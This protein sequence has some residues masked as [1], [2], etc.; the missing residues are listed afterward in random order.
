GLSEED[1]A[2]TARTEQPA[3]LELAPPVRAAD[4]LSQARRA[5]VLAESSGLSSVSKTTDAKR[6][7]LRTRLTLGAVGAAAVVLGGVALGLRYH[8]SEGRAAIEPISSRHAYASEPAK[9]I[10]LSVGLTGPIDQLTS[11]ARAG[12]PDAEL[13]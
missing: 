8:V 5:A 3:S 1:T 7:K 4:F 13:T 12:E 6:R 11:R 9:A 10:K 2:E